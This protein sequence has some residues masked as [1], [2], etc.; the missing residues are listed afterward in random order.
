VATSRRRYEWLYLYGFVHPT[1]GRVVWLLLPSVDAELF[2]L[3]L[4]HFARDVGAGPQRRILLVLD[5]AGWHASASL[6][7]PEGIHLMQLP[8]Y[9]PELQP[10]EHLWPLVREV[11]ANQFIPDMD[12]LEDLLL[13]RC[14]QLAEDSQT[15]QR[16]TDFHWWS[17]AAQAEVLHA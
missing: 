6:R 8:P 10:A 14:R 3:A 5:G 9:S 1:S 15:I 17:H 16:S 4:E 12:R 2:Q 13:R 11:V 7:V